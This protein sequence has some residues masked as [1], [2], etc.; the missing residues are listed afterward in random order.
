MSGEIMLVSLS[1]VG[2]WLL[3]EITAVAKWWIRTRRLQVVL[4][5]ELLTISEEEAPRVWGS[6]HRSLQ[7]V[8]NGMIEPA[9]PLPIENQAY[10][11]HYGDSIFTTN[12]FRRKS[13]EFVHKYVH[14]TNRAIQDCREL[15]EAVRKEA[16]NDRIASER[17][18]E[19]RSLIKVAMRNAAEAQW[20]ARRHL[21]HPVLPLLEI[22][23][24]AHAAYHAF[25]RAIS[26]R[27]SRIELSSVGLTKEQLMNASADQLDTPRSRD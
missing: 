11:R 23:G 22:D 1:L 17:I 26:E 3:G 5:E 27:I 9:L 19:F 14:E 15:L 8:V 16:K 20:H 25:H 4:L 10:S 7:F 21:D 24:P 12:R 2:G 18:E 13:L 6:F